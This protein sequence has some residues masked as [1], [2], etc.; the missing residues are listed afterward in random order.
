MPG[1]SHEWRSLGYSPQVAKS[2]TRLSDF[3]FFLPAG[4]NPEVSPLLEPNNS[5]N[6]SPEMF[7]DTQTGNA[8]LN[9]NDKFLAQTHICKKSALTRSPLR[10]R[11]S[12]LLALQSQVSEAYGFSVLS[13]FKK[14]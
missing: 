7:F 14:S 2:R 10:Q 13:S 11:L 8:F 5:D 6:D 3:T 12:E 1:E 4:T 9:N